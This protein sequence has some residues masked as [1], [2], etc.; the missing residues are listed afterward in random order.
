M[1]TEYTLP[2]TV[3]ELIAKLNSTPPPE[4]DGLLD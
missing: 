1:S 3:S 4:R 2:Y